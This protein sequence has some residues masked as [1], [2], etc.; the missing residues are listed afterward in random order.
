[1]LLLRT[2]AHIV[3]YFIN[4]IFGRYDELSSKGNVEYIAGGNVFLTWNVLF[5]FLILLNFLT[6]EN[7]FRF[8]GATQN[9]IRVAQ[10]S[11]PKPQ[12]P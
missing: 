4:V 6:S 12:K 2:I 10:V 5:H 8:P 9:S 1:M 3:S 11:S 7:V